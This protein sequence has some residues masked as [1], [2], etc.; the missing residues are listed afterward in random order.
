M[1]LLTNAV[2]PKRDVGAGDYFRS[3]IQMSASKRAA[4]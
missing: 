2:N 1:S 4:P 3:T